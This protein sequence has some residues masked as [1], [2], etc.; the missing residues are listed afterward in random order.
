MKPSIITITLNPA[1]DKSS[2]I[3]ALVPEKKLRCSQPVFQ[4]GGGGVN[5]AR[6]IH[7]LGGKALAIYLAGGYSGIFFKELLEKEG[8]PQLVI[9]I[10]GHTRENFIVTDL[11]Q[12]RQYR[13]GM[14]GPR[15]TEQEWKALLQQLQQLEA[16]DYIVVSGS[17]PA[18]APTDMLVQIA[19]IARQKKA[20]LVIDSAG[21]ALKEVAGEGAFLLK[22]NLGELSQLAGLQWIAANE[23]EAIARRLL[24]DGLC[25]VLLISMGATGAM[26]VTM[27]ETVQITPPQV[28]RI[29]TVGAGDSLVAGMVWGLQ[30]NY[31]L[32]E[33]ARFGVACGT[34]ATLRPGTLLCT[35][36]DAERL[37]KETK[38]TVIT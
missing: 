28:E 37:Y 7:Q 33:A 16:P 17:M 25:E 26:L 9:P 3:A 13:F 31:S 15:I 27:T 2:T 20:R 23:V 29:S 11:A 22:P 12:N 21:Q 38:A 14:P 5:V 32:K 34:A 36:K 8:I 6:A 19:R 4:P 24:T 18:G 10:G 1:I 35:S 30:N